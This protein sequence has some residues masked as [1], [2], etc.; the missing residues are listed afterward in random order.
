MI[1]FCLDPYW[2]SVSP[3]GGKFHSDPRWKLAI[4]GTPLEKIKC[5]YEFPDQ[6]S[7]AGVFYFKV[8]YHAMRIKISLILS[9]KR[10]PWSSL[11]ICPTC[12]PHLNTGSAPVYTSCNY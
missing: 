10:V 1:N 4:G 11:M 7:F 5:F 8:E 9:E 3:T 12:N 2:T 6:G